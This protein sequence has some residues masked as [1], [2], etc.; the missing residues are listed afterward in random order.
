[1]LVKKEKKNHL[2]KIPDIC[3]Y[4]LSQYL[5]TFLYEASEHQLQHYV[6]RRYLELWFTNC[7]LNKN[8]G[9]SHSSYKGST[10]LNMS[11]TAYR[12]YNLLRLVKY[13]HTEL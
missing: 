4:I 10:N 8:L 2:N 1:M 13:L 5:T 11:S 12:L 3:G 9:G 6:A 7:R